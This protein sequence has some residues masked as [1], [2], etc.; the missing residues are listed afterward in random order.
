MDS[1]EVMMDDGADFCSEDGNAL[2]SV[3]FFS[4]RVL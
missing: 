4:I 1:K 3:E 2:K